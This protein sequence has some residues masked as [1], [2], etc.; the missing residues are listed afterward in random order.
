MEI[1]EAHY[2]LAIAKYK[3]I[4]KAAKSLYISQ[5]S[6]SKYLQNLEYKL[7]LKLFQHIHGE[8]VPTNVGKTYLSYAQKL[9][10]IEKEWN[11]EL[12]DYQ[13]LKKGELNIA[14][15]IIRSICFIP[16][17]I[18]KF[19]KYFPDIKVNIFEISS[20]IEKI[21]NNNDNNIDFAIYNVN[22]LPKSIDYEILGKNEIV[23]VVDKHHPIIK[24]AIQKEGFQHLWVDINKIKN[25]PV[26]S[27]HDDQITKEVLNSYLES[28]HIQLHVWM[29]TRNSEVALQMVKNQTGITFLSDE[30]MKSAYFNKNLVCLSIG[31]QP[32]Y[33]TMIAAYRH[34]QYLSEYHKKYLEIAKK[35]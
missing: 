24:T 16:K 26:I 33:T 30:Y 35:Y 27:L 4:N 2:I 12:A 31:D 5:P 10:H 3:S 6:L 11:H 17:T 22:Q 23:L 18:T 28:Q 34:G 13:N 1:K 7:N 32:L 15:P 8:Y 20:T 14:I 19:H 29:K 25:E 21:L 9:V